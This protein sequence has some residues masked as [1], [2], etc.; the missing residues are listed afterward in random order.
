MSRFILLTL[1]ISTNYND[2]FLLHWVPIKI[3]N[4]G[5]PPTPFN[6]TIFTQKQLPY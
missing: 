2:C 6:Q 5:P 1:L 4:L 3:A